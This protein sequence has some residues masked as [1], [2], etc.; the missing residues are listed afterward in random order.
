MKVF[1]RE[2]GQKSS[3]ASSILA[4]SLTWKHLDV[5][6]LDLHFYSCLRAHK[7]Q[8]WACLDP[9]LQ[10]LIY[11]VRCRAPGLASEAPWGLAHSSSPAEHHP[12][13]HH[14]P[15]PSLWYLN[16]LG[17]FS[18]LCLCTCSLCLE[19]SSSTLGE[20]LFIP[21]NPT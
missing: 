6:Y 10:S 16:V 8:G 7:C 19:H 9:V 4:A 5:C 18:P 14:P 17:S 13:P 12:P 20:L 2:G 11:R 15:A 1:L 21:Q 3:S